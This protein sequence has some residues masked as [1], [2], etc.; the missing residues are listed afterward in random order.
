MCVCARARE[1][2]YIYIYIIH[3]WI[4]VCRGAATWREEGTYHRAVSHANKLGVAVSEVCSC[5]FLIQAAARVYGRSMRVGSRKEALMSYT[6]LVISRLLKW[7]KG[8]SVI[9]PT[10]VTVPCREGVWFV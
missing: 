4:C 1:Y 9:V 7:K 2:I 3:I 5:A 10:R 6:H 8:N